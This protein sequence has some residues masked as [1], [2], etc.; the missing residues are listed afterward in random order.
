MRPRRISRSS[1]RCRRPASSPK[2]DRR[3]SPSA[4]AIRQGLTMPRLQ[5]RAS[6]P[7]SAMLNSP[8]PAAQERRVKLRPE[9][10]AT[11]M[12][13][14]RSRDPAPRAMTPVRRTGEDTSSAPLMDNPCLAAAR[15]PHPCP[16]IRHA[17]DT[18]QPTG[19]RNVRLNKI[20]PG[21]LLDYSTANPSPRPGFSTNP[22]RQ[23]SQ[24]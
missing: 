23:Q 8:C 11:L 7:T 16:G 3:S 5:H 12:G 24:C 10:A 19:T 14:M 4:T 18:T 2:A 1:N 13:R 20:L 6:P 9:P 17:R 15:P 22:P 21:C